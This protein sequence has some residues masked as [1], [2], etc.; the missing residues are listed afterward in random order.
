MDASTNPNRGYLRLVKATDLT[1]WLLFRLTGVTTAT[2]YRKLSIDLVDSSD[3]NPFSNADSLFLHFT[4]A[5]DA[6]IGGDANAGLVTA[7]IS[8]TGHGLSVGD[9]VRHDGSDYVEGQADS[10][11]NSRVA[12]VVIDVIDVDTFVLQSA[13]Y[14]EVLSGLTAGSQYFLSPSTPGAITAT[15]PTADG[16]VSK[17]VLIATG[18]TTGWIINHRGWELPFG[19]ADSGVAEHIK[20]F[21]DTETVTSGD[22]K[23][24]FQC[25]RDM[26]GMELGDVELSVST[27]SSSGI[28]QVQV[29]NLTQA[30]DMLSTRVQVDQGEFHS[31][32]AGTQPVID[33]SNDDVAH[34]DI[35]RLDVDAAGTNARGL[36]IVLKFFTGAGWSLQGPPGATG[37]T[38]ATGAGATG[39]TGSQGATGSPGG[40]TGATGPAG[41]QGNT[42]ATGPG[43]ASFKGARVTRTALQVIGDNTL[44]PVSFDT[45]SFDEGGF[46]SLSNPTRLTAPE[47]GRYLV[48]YQ[49]EFEANTTGSRHARIRL[50]GSIYVAYEWFDPQ[51]LSPRMNGSVLIEMPAGDYVELVVFQDSGGDLDLTQQDEYSPFFWIAK[52]EGA[53]GEGSSDLFNY[54]F[55]R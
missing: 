5:G 54:L 35:I 12:G 53:S 48:G 17:P 22:G 37:A 13:G 23:W 41:A 4:P 9:W 39:A 55:T 6:G 3:A 15:E 46:F 40:A 28:V 27:V 25:S 52:Q 45:E 14:V 49:I 8:Q 30:V 51:A 42:G 26:D 47:D 21:L 2:G 29:H 20:I 44:T 18:T 43:V 50:N 19:A 11:V 24:Y 38:G 36:E 16:D 32:D 33:T 34:G 10:V 1:K 31:K 7:E